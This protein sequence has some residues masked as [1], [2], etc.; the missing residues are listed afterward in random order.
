MKLNEKGQQKLLDYA[1]QCK[2]NKSVLCTEMPEFELEDF[3]TEPK[4]LKK[5]PTIELQ[6]DEAKIAQDALE[7][8]GVTTSGKFSEKCYQLFETIYKRIA[9]AVAQAEGK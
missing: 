8:I 7:V 3:M 4:E 1:F 5:W 6:L 2:K 9:Q